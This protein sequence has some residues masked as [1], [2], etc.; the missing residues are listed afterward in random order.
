MMNDDL[1]SVLTEVV[2]A[3]YFSEELYKKV[4]RAL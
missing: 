3:D 4:F 1:V 2:S